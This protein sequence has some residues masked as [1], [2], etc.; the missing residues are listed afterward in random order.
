MNLAALFYVMCG[1]VALGVC[2]LA[3]LLVANEAEYRR[4]DA[5]TADPCKHPR[6]R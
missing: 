1:L 5:T 4:D 3:C 6:K 2:I